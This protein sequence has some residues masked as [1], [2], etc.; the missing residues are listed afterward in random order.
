[1]TVLVSNQKDHWISGHLVIENRRESNK[2]RIQM[3]KG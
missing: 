3:A 1:M 2:Q